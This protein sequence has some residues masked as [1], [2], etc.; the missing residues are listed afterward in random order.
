MRFRVGVGTATYTVMEGQPF[1]LPTTYT[2]QVTLAATLTGTAAV[3][4][5]L[6]PDVH[7]VVGTVQATGTY[8][9]RLFEAAG[10]SKV[11]VYLDALLP[12]G[13]AATVEIQNGDGGTWT[14]APLVAS[15]VLDGDWIEYR[16]ELTGFAYDNTR[17]RLSLAGSASAVP[18]VRNLKVAVI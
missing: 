14:A 7:L 12:S 8:V 15:A 5:T 10:G 4:P 6:F 18:R 2:G 1:A 9:S 16:H 3:S 17:V 11:T 13:A